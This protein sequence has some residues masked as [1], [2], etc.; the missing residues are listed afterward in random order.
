[1]I[2]TGRALAL[3]LAD[4]YERQPGTW[5]TDG[6][7]DRDGEPI[8]TA[9]PE[10]VAFCPVL[11]VERLR[12]CERTTRDA[13]NEFIKLFHANLRGTFGVASIARWNDEP[14]R[15]VAEVIP[16]LREIGGAA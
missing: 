9:Y 1:M 11:A 3:A 7:K 2:T 5:T 8:D 13:A 4:Q 10:A 14:G 12:I 16:K 15:T 6:P